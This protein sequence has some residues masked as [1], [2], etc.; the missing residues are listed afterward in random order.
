MS[1][2]ADSF[3]FPTSV[4]LREKIGQLIF[5]RVGSNLPPVKTV[6]QD[7]ERALRLLAECPV[8]GLILFNG[9]PDAKESLAR[10]QA[11][12]NVPLLIGSD[13][14]RGVGQQVK[15]Y[16]LFPHSMALGKG[17]W[18]FGFFIEALVREARDMGIHIVF[19]PVAD[20]NTNPLNPII[21]IRA[22]SETMDRAAELVAQYVKMAEA[23]DLLTTAKHFPGHGDTFQDSHDSLPSVDH[24]LDELRDRELIPFQAAIDAGCSLI[25][26]AHIAFPRIDPS[27]LPATLSR[28][29]LED[30]LRDEMGF[31]GVICSDSLLMAG[32]RDRFATEGELAL[33]ALNA[34]VDVLL[35]FEDPIA[36]LEHLLK[37]HES[38]ALDEAR[39]DQAL[40]RLLAL[41]NKIFRRPPVPLPLPKNMPA[42]ESLSELF[43]QTAEQVAR[44][45]IEVFNVNHAVLPLDREAATAVILLKPFETAIEPPEQPLG[46]AVRH[47]F[48]HANYA[49]LGPRADEAAY[50]MAREAALE[51]KQVVLA[52]IVRPAAWHA[53]G[54][55]PEQIEFVRRM[56]AERKG[57]VLVSLGAP[58]S[59]DEFPDAAM[60]ICTYSDVPVSQQAL[61]EF[62]LAPA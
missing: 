40:R 12:S 2:S 50:R 29:I 19:G 10:L 52:M 28:I 7:E 46:A 38:G 54:L 60:R 53:Y 6:E 5:V 20:I 24:S 11:V 9:G 61:V 33:E 57:V 14:E 1:T 35:D 43:A 56:T 23:T 30:L 18:G 44:N 48:R 3:S 34:G 4:S 13:I 17:D 51:A 25:M 16:T 39:V 21:S 32:V 49:Q 47:R 45:A 55:R 42:T 26:T 37:A 15:G 31:E 62:L 36:V 58:Y 27:G 41:K 59:L 22:F 8:G